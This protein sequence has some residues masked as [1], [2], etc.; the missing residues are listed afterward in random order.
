MKVDMAKDGSPLVIGNI[1][2]V[3]KR[4]GGTCRAKY[5]GM[6]VYAAFGGSIHHESRSTKTYRFTTKSFRFIC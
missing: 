2:L 5:N 4:A 3:K 6:T 1:Y